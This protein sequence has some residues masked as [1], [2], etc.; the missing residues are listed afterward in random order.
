VGDVGHVLAALSYTD[1]AERE[2]MPV[3]VAPVDWNAV[4]NALRAWVKEYGTK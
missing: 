2:P 1:D 3:M 4:K